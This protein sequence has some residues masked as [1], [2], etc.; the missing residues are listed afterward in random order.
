MKIVIFYEN[1]N[2]IGNFIILSLLQVSRKSE[3]NEIA[4]GNHE[5]VR[6]CYQKHWK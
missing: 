1:W 5:K 4:Q 6:K 3:K 2:F